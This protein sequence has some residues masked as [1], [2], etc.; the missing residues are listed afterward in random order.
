DAVS[1][2]LVEEAD[3]TLRLSTGEFLPG[4]DEVERRGTDPGSDV[5]RVV[6]DVRHQVVAARLG[7]ADAL[8]RTYLARRQPGRAI[9]HLEEAL[10]L[11]PDRD[12]LARRLVD[13]YE[14]G[15]QRRRA[16]RLR[17]EYGL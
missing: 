8:A 6:V 11:R 13:A 12:E 1:D 16:A 7:L 2:Q 9:P 5:G 17:E 10:E 3:E 15:G 14:L 4:W